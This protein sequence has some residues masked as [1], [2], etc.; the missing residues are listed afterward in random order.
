MA[1]YIFEYCIS[2][3]L[4]V[5]MS[6][7]LYTKNKHS[8][9][10]KIFGLFNLSVAIWQFGFFRVFLASSEPEAL[11]WVKFIWTGVIL[12]PTFFY[13]FTIVFFDKKD[14]AVRRLIASSY[15]LSGIFIAALWSTHW[16]IGGAYHYFWGYYGKAGLLQ[17]LFMGFFTVSFGSALFIWY[18][19]YREMAQT[20][21]LEYSRRKY[22]FLMASVGLIGAVDFLPNYGVEIY[23]FAAIPITLAFAFAS[24]AIIKH[25]LMDIQTVVHKTIM[26]AAMSSLVLLPVGGLFYVAHPWIHNL[27]PFQFALAVGMVGLSLIPYVKAIQP[28]IDHLFQRRKY[29]LQ[30]ILQDF[31][32]E[33]S[34]LKGLDELVTK[35]QSTITSVLYPENTSIVLFDVKEETFKPFWISNLAKSFSA[36]QHKSFLK[37][38]ENKNRISELDLIENEPRYSKIKESAKKYF[39]ETQARLVVPVI[40]DNKLL[41]VINL[42]QKKNLKPYNDLDLDFLASLRA[43]ASIAF[44][45]AV[46]YDDVNKMSLELKQWATELE[47]KVEERTKELAESKQEVEKAYTKLKELDAIKTKFFA[48][49]SHELRTPL[50]L[51]L[52][53]LESMLKGEMGALHKS[54]EGHVQIMYQ[55]SLRLLKMINNLLD[56]A[57]IDAG[58]MQLTLDRLNLTEFIKGVVASVSPMADK[59]KIRLAFVEGQF[60]PEM[61]CDREKVERVLLNLIFNSLKFTEPGGSVTVRC[62]MRP[63]GEGEESGDRAWV[64]VADT[65]IGFP[66][67][68]RTQIFE[69]FSQVDASASRKHEGSGIGLS[70]AKELVELHGGRIWAESEPGK[71]TVM[72]FILPMDLAVPEPEG[73]AEERR[74]ARRRERDRRAGERRREEDWTRVLHTAAEYSA[75]DIMKEAVA[76]PV[77]ATVGAS[78]PEHTILLIEDNA[79]MRSFIAFQLQEEFELIQARDGIEGVELAVQHHPSLIISDVMMPGKDGYQVCREIKS[80]PHTRHIPVVL[81][82]AKADLSEK[83]SG[84]EFGADDYLTKPFNGQELKAKIWSLIRLRRLERE[85]QE[86]S[87]ELEQTVKRLGE[88]QSQLVHSEK[89]AAMGL[90]V[91]GVAH[92]V[93]NPVSFA[94]GSLSN[95]RRYLLQ[96][97]QAL[98]KQP[99]TREV[100]IQFNNLVQDIEQS[101]SIVKAG[102][103]RTEGIVT[104]LKAFAR[105]DEQNFKRVDIHDGLE[106]TIKLIRHELGDRITLHREYGFRGEV[107]IIPGQI[108]Q[109]FMNLLQ[110][111]IHAIPDKGEIR[112]RSWE[113]GDRIHVA[114]RD[115]GA[116]IKKEHLGRIFEPFFTTKEVG[117]G[118]GL[119]LSVSYRIIENHGGKITVSSE[120]GHGAEFVITLPKRQTP[121]PPAQRISA[122]PI[123]V[124]GTS[125]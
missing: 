69:R 60:M 44:S 111:A 58:K 117:R 29:D 105:K 6:V 48:N 21:F 35:L 100:L 85:I 81:L 12:I 31:I 18:K 33:I 36:E 54:Q 120:E 73:T 103:D 51:I 23:P 43:E 63:S 91:A 59:K 57:K 125:R 88:T 102:L 75:A 79:D 14:K 123:S 80:D 95:L 96:V 32:H 78:P 94:K 108:N 70:L 86:R 61:V 26:W 42:G 101:L 4:F 64:T 87:E 55:N 114:V 84:L 104:D 83:I 116:G 99:E 7:Y 119:G 74:A 1:P 49:V 98:E 121:E 17:Y 27:S 25:Q 13:H 40:H 11:F 65:G 24:Y 112:L 89:M 90:L 82:T 109:V 5:A 77:P 71:G 30:K 28:R 107:E 46:L 92:E 110:N 52:A 53:P 76:A 41:G 45:N 113:E 97:R 10:Q 118:T 38:L 37:W 16:F 115:S 122:E 62:G 66:M 47:R 67:E 22:V 68:Y 39:N 15:I 20:S 34:V 56:L 3:L 50:T 124:K 106:A 19:G 72:T 2:S 9:A 8:M 93:N